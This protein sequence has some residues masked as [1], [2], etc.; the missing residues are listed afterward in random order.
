M[1]ERVFGRGVGHRSALR[2]EVASDTRL[3]VETL[4]SAL[5]ERLHGTAAF[6]AKSY[7]D[8]PIIFTG[9]HL[10]SYTPGPI[11][12]ARDLARDSEALCHGEA[13]TFLRQ[14]RFLADFEESYDFSGN[15]SRY[16]PTY[17]AMSNDQL[18]G[19]FDWRRRW[20][21]EKEPSASDSFVYLYAYELI[22]LVGVPDATSAWQELRR[23]RRAYG[24]GSDRMAAN[25]DRWSDDLVVYYGLDPHLLQVLAHRE[26]DAALLVLSQCKT[27]PSEE[28]FDALMC[29]SSYRIEES[30]FYKAYPSDFKQVAVETY[31]AIADH[32]DRHLK[33]SLL[34]S[35]FGVSVEQDYQMFGNAVFADPLHPDHADFEVDPIDHFHCRCGRWSRKRYVGNLHPNR[36]LGALMKTIDATMRTIYDFKRPLRAPITTKYVNALVVRHTEL[37]LDERREAKGRVVRIDRSKLREIRAN[38]ALTCKHL[39]VAQESDEEEGEGGLSVSPALAKAT[40]DE[41]SVLEV[42]KSESVGQVP[43]LLTSEERDVLCTLL[44]DGSLKELE[45]K[46]HIMVSLLIESINEKLYDTFGDVVIDVQQDRPRVIA[47]YK[48]DLKDMMSI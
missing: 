46:R 1:Q 12:H 8:Q 11:A 27:R 35:Y 47:D 21:H 13:W 40:V 16:F 37:L 42:Q 15:F 32:H 25:L 22:H 33:H 30:S 36:K 44:E 4:R 9:S 7:A 45:R 26:Q 24:P 19:Y 10:R 3:D 31:R 23:L 14:A 20:R 5:D 6:S 2:P 17:E 38:A 28:L 29:L 18:R 39:I 34:Q 48:H 43:P 41:P